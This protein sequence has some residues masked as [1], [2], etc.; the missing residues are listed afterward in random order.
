MHLFSPAKLNLYLDILHKR[1]DGYHEI[2]TLMQALNFGDEI[3]LSFNDSGKITLKS[4]NPQLPLDNSNLVWKAI[5]LYYRLSRMPFRGVEVYIDKRIPMAAGLGGGS[6]N[7]IT[8][9]KALDQYHGNV[10]GLE[11]LEVLAALLGSDTVFFLEPGTWVCGG[12]GEKRI[13]RFQSREWHFI[14]I[15][16][17]YG[18]STPKVYSQY[19]LNLTN[20]PP[21]NS[22]QTLESALAAGKVKEFGSLIYNSLQ[23]AA[24][25]TYPELWTLALEIEQKTREKVYLS[26][27]GSTLYMIFDR[28]EKALNM[29]DRLESDFEKNAY[30]VAQ[31]WMVQ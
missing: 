12:R 15:F 11:K 22:L 10:M 14:L 1:T 4:D 17:P 6:S 8:V 26:G 31:T 27:S 19:I 30:A 7:A 20:R 9:L 5:E 3:D 18:C 16:P 28:R 24:F 23:D 29:K 21:E 25:R 13:S 2:K